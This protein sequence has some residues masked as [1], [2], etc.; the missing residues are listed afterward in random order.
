MATRRRSRPLERLRLRRCAA[1]APLALQL[2]TMTCSTSTRPGRGAEAI[3]N[4]VIFDQESRFSTHDLG[5]LFPRSGGGGFLIVNDVIL[6]R[7]AS[8]E[9]PFAEGHWS[10]L[11]SRL[12]GPL[13]YGRQKKVPVQIGRGREKIRKKSLVCRVKPLPCG[14]ESSCLC[15][16]LGARTA[17]AMD[18]LSETERSFCPEVRARTLQH[19][20]GIRKF[21]GP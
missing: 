5:E 9:P 2:L 6:T 7:I 20:V 13:A 8:L 3:V 10:I 1:R 21:W 19:S 18:D 12:A 15:A 4:D 17:R 16:P 14:I 11:R